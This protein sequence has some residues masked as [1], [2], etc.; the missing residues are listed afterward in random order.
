MNKFYG[1]RK[2]LICLRCL[3]MFP[4]IIGSMCFFSIALAIEVGV[5]EEGQQNVSGRV[6]DRNGEPLIGVSV[7]ARQGAGGTSTDDQG[8]YVLQVSSEETS[9]VF[10]YIGYHSKEIPIAGQQTVDVILEEDAQALGEVVV[11]GYG[12]QK[13]A[14]VTGSVSEVKGADIVKSPQP[15][16]SNS[17]AGRFSGLVATNRGGEPG[18]D[19]S[20]IRIRG[21]STTGSTDVLVVVD[22]VPG[23]VGGLERLDPNDIE[24]ISVLKDASAAVYGSR[25]ANGVI[26]VTTKRGGTGK[27]TVSYSFNQGFSS[28]TRLP[29][30]ADAATYATLRNEISYYGNPNGG[31]NQF[32]SEEEIERFRTGSDPERYP[33][34][35]WQREVLAST[36]LQNQHNLSVNGGTETTKYFASVGMLSQD[37]IFRDGVT[38][39][40]QY[41]FR[42][43]I[44]FDVTERFKV[45]LS[46]AGREE[47]RKFPTVSAG[48]I[49]RNIY[50]AYPTVLSRYANGLPST[51]IE[52]NNPVM[53]VTDAGGIN[54]NPTLIFNGILRASYDLPFLD[55]LMLDGFLAI[56]RSQESGKNFITPYLVYGYN[57]SSE[58]Y[59]PRTVGELRAQ[60]EQFQEN[61][62]LTTA[63][64]KLNYQHSFGD[65]NLSAFAAYEQ[66]ERRLSQFE[67]GRRNFPSPLTPELSQGGTALEDRTNAG[68]S[69][70]ESRTSFISRLNYNY[71]EKYLV[72][73][74]LRVDGSSI[75]PRDNRFGYFPGISAGWRLSEEEWFRDRVT[76]FD[77]LKLRAS[78]GELGG[79][80]VGANQFINNYRF[81]SVYTLGDGL[82]PGID[83]EKLANPSIT[84]EVSK[85]TDLGFNARFL[86]K[87]NMEFIYFMENRSRILLPRNASIPG[88]TGIVNPI[89]ND[90]TIP[91]VP[92]ENIGRVD[93]RGLEATLGYT[94]TG[95][96]SFGISGNVTYVKSNVV[97]RD[98]SPAILPYQSL[99]GRPLNT[100]LLYRTIGIFRSQGDLDNYP[101]V[102][103]ARVGDLIFEDYNQDGVITADDMVRTDLGNIPQLTFGLNLTASW[104]NFDFSAVLAGQGRARQYIL[105]EAGT[106]GNFYRTWA[107]NRWSPI[108]QEGT[109]PRVDE[110]ASSAISGGL[111][112][113]DFWLFNTAFLRLKNIELGYNLPGSFLEKVGISSLRLFANGFNLFT[114]TK[115]KDFD[116]EGDSESGQFYPQQRIVNLGANIRF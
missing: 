91:L 61:T 66:A 53:M 112:R 85:K 54:E 110:R 67:A 12:T 10:S 57:A 75:F 28:P 92:S 107:D 62:S 7:R 29:K 72:E 69:W 13:R 59:E 37:G 18:Y 17:L 14:T 105:A 32:Y 87:F 104:R 15:N 21:A 71:K 41:N 103:G 39:F 38:N 45:G 42:S 22:G 81:N 65:H 11:V 48:D 111:Y 95:N 77:D 102:P 30:M 40:K 88:S 93:N 97:F 26:L 6:S 82:Y 4:I 113:N 56:D 36:A 76:F 100:D 9:L 1:F 101:H 3:I 20:Q 35:D 83:L 99:T 70:R 58:E 108:Q 74:Q 44:D 47:K 23:Q 60:L 8:K 94:H 33:N 52:N 63:H 89:E 96:M 115:L 34:T 79:D 25:A 31:L 27:P 78:Y 114:I 80:N 51:G 46:A 49:F 24:S 116:P 43:N 68:L 5:S 50:R 19:G 64:I 86:N 90:N 98:E 109:Y 84:W 2:E 106:V 55:G 16:V 73:A